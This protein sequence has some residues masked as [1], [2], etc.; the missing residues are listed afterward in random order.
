MNQSRSNNQERIFAARRIVWFLA[1]IVIAGAVGMIVYWRMPGL[2]LQAQDGLL[3]LR[4]PQSVSQDL[5]IVAIDETS[6]LRFGRFPWSRRIMAQV[7]DRIS[8]A[9]PR[10]IALDVLYSDATETEADQSLADAIGRNRRVIV[11]AQ[12]I[13]VQDDD[14]LP[15]AEWLEPLPAIANAAATIGHVNVSTDNDGVA[16]ALLLRQMDDNAQAH[17][18]MAVELLRIA[19]GIPASELRELPGSIGIGRRRIP[20]RY[21]SAPI[22]I[23]PTDDR[24]GI[25]TVRAS[26]MTINYAGP[27]GTFAGQTIS[28]VDLIDGKIPA[29][30]LRDKIV[31]VGATANA[32][33]DRLASPFTRHESDDGGQNATLMPGVEILANALQTIQSN[34]FIKLTPDWLAVFCSLLVAAGAVL[35]LGQVQGR[36]E[37]PATLIAL[38][39]LAGL[40]LITTYLVFSRLLII[41]PVVPMLVAFVTAV[42]LTLLHRSR[43]AGIELDSR[44]V[45]LTSHDRPL[46]LASPGHDDSP[47][48]MIAQ[49]TLARGVC[50]LQRNRGE[51]K[52]NGYRVMAKHG[53]PLAAAIEDRNGP[54]LRLPRPPYSS[55]TEA[56]VREEPADNYF[57]SYGE[58]SLRAIT[59]SLGEYG[60]D[61]GA[62]V[63]AYQSDQPPAPETLQVCREMAS[64]WLVSSPRRNDYIAPWNRLRLFRKSRGIQWKIRTLGTLQR[65][66]LR[67]A[68]FIDRAMR[69]IEDGLL[70]TG[71]D[72]QVTFANPRAGQIFG[73]SEHSLIGRNLFHHLLDMA[74]TETTDPA[75]GQGK[76]NAVLTRL[77]IDRAPFEREI[78]IAAGG[79]HAQDRHYMLRLGVV[80]ENDNGEGPVIGIVATLSDITRQ[81]EL[82]QMKN[83]V[84]ALVTHELRTPITAIQGM[85]EILSQHEYNPGERRE[86]H[87][88]INEESKRLSRLIDEYLD[89]TRLESGARTLR[90]TAVR[91]TPLLERTLLMLEPI[92]RQRDTRL[93][94]RFALNLP[95]LLADADLLMQAANN[96]VTNAI[97][98]SP[99]GREVTIETGKLDDEIWI[100]VSD[101]GHGIP[102]QDLD[103]IFEKFYRVSRR[104][105]A[106]VT[107]T[108]LGLPFVSEVMMLHGGRLT[109]ESEVGVGSTFTM[110]FKVES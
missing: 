78:E 16:R 67:R 33:G 101:Q 41:L 21:E 32:L 42:P 93:I 53:S 69:S 44:I 15:R 14:G 72:G 34:R 88:A 92:A 66:L 62:M 61:Y 104:E 77:L 98:Y 79:G 99:P 49:L 65:T 105:D 57:S 24:K 109:V 30:K 83:D 35:T 70:I 103:H 19:D 106:D 102:E 13:Q 64:S 27:T 31:L 7:I 29:E 87:E 81:H 68:G 9:G 59:I 4:G 5:V 74:F 37:W 90:R 20:V 63:I 51:G 76:L 48:P 39:M 54:V 6:L 3:R 40:L 1:T 55:V 71:V 46:G 58:P 110:F 82:Q 95:P 75:R 11:A 45:E 43:M 50:L 2:S 52:H 107:G 97:K 108:G 23:G 85:S 18:A 56:L 26:N 89:L 47:A 94:R 73:L 96:L 17:W 28:I 38:A 91:L 60:E 12:L 25:E 84:L 80:C 22:I 86:M 8:A 100:R 36:G 10:A